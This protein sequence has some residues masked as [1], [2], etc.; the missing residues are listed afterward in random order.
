[1]K[2]SVSRVALVSTLILPVAMP[3]SAQAQPAAVPA[4][5]DVARQIDAYLDGAVPA[6]RPG[7]TVVVT[8]GGKTVYAGARGLADVAAGRRLT[9]DSVI[10]IGSITKQFTAAVILQLA[11]EGKLTLDDPVTKFIPGYPA[12]GGAATVRQLLNHT[13]GIKSYTGVP[14]WMVPANTGKPHTTAEMIATFRNLPNDFPAGTQWAYNNSGYVLLGAII[15]K[16]TGKPW[17]DAIQT[18]IAKPLGLKTIR[19][20]GGAPGADWASAYGDEGEAAQAID[21]SVPHAAGGLVG[22]VRDLATWANALHHGRVLKPASYAMMIAPTRLS[23]GTSNP[24]G[25]GLSNGSVRGQAIIEHSGGI[26]GGATDSLYVPSQDLFVA[27]FANSD[28]PVAMP[29]VAIRRIAGI[30]MGSPFPVFTRQPM[31]M[32]AVEPMFGIYAS[33]GAE[34]VERRFFARDGRFFI[35]REGGSEREVFA[36]GDGRFSAEPRAIEWF[37]IVPASG[38]YAMEWHTRGEDAIERMA[39][40][41]PIPAEVATVTLPRATLER[42]IGV[43]ALPMGRLTVAWGAGDALTAQ[44]TGQPALSLEPIGPTEFRVVGIDARVE[45]TG[46]TATIV[47]GGR[48]FTGNRAP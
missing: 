20:G 25:F 17:Y 30:A 3:A 34:P 22:S 13:S 8:R 14:G 18:R 41:G 43:Y 11:E 6:G 39:R 28:R 40:T 32:A 31:V 12:P 38:G 16:V 37:R 1:M 48:R 44:L 27:V 4:T 47:Q 19:Y 45:L 29:G 23:D 7:V 24:Y 9:P 35:K 42:Y 46:D 21:M 5:A 26:F 2:L 10:R 33:G 36:V 15:E